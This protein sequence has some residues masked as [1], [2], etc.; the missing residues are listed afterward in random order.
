MVPTA[1]LVQHLRVAADR[2]REPLAG[3]LA[4]GRPAVRRGCTL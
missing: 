2:A 3:E 1:V 4:G